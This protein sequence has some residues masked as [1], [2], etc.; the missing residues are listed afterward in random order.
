MTDISIITGL[1]REHSVTKYRKTLLCAQ[2]VAGE[3]AEASVPA[4]PRM[5]WE[6]DLAPLTGIEVVVSPDSAP[7]TWR[8]TQH[9]H[10]EVTGSEMPERSRIVTHENC[11]VLAENPGPGTGELFDYDPQTGRS[12]WDDWL[13]D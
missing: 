8:L 11:T 9:D 2:D 12:S 7:G 3:L 6:V 4:R 5:P 10:C 13:R 1:I